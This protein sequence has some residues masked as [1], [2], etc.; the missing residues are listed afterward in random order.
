MSLSERTRA[1]TPALPADFRRQAVELGT[2]G[3]VVANADSELATIES[4]LR[5]R[6]SRLSV[7]SSSKAKMTTEGRRDH[8]EVR[9]WQGRSI[10]SQ[11]LSE[12][13][14]VRQG[15]QTDSLQ[16]YR[17]K[18]EKQHGRLGSLI[19]FHRQPDSRCCS[20]TPF[21]SIGALLA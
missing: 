4:C 16:I 17:N 5:T 21:Q 2:A 20:D 9:G 8:L 3:N 18:F 12:G 14:V 7:D 13:G 6:T 11:S 15:Q 10:W 1:I 19:C